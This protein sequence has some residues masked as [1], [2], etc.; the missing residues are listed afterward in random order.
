M[1]RIS[2]LQLGRMMQA[3][4]RAGPLAGAATPMHGAPAKRPPLISLQPYWRLL[5]RYLS[6]LVVA[7]MLR[8][9]LSW[10]AL[11]LVMS[12]VIHSALPFFYTDT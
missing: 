9:N 5:R 8:H 12:G 3:L 6:L 10:P 2:S 1:R 11:H 4:Q 7:K